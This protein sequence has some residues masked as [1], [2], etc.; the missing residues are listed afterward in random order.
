MQMTIIETK[1]DPTVNGHDMENARWVIGIPGGQ[2][3]MD[4]PGTGTYTLHLVPD[5]DCPNLETWK[6]VMDYGSSPMFWGESLVWASPRT[7]G[8]LVHDVIHSQ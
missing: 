4:R 2:I 5:V 7:I 3:I 8:H 6:M 1:I